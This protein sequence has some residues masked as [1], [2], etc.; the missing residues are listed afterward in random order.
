MPVN[1]IAGCRASGSTWWR[2]GRL[3]HADAVPAARV[4]DD[5][6]GLPRA[7]RRQPGDEVGEGVVG[8][9]EEHELGAGDDVGHLAHR[10]PGQEVGGPGEAR[11]RHRRDP[12]D[13]GGR[14]AA[15]AAPEHRADPARTDDSDG[16]AGGVLD[17]VHDPTRYRYCG[18]AARVAA[19]PH[20]RRGYGAGVMVP[21]REA[22]HDALYGPR[23]FYRRAEG[24]AGHFTTSTHGPLGAAPRGGARRL[25][26]REGATHVVDVGCGRGELLTHLHGVRPDLRLTGVDVVERPGAC[27]MP[28]RGSR[29]PGG[30]AL[31]DGLDDLD[32]RA[33]RRPRVA[34]RRAVHGR[35]GRGAGAAARSCSSTRRPVRSRSAARRRPTSSRG[36]RGTGPSR[37]CRCGAGSRSAPPGTWPGPTSSAAVRR[38]TLLAVDYGH[39]RGDRPAARHPHGIPRRHARRPGARRV[40][41]PHRARRRRRPRATTRCTTQRDG[42]ARPRRRPR[43]PPTSRL[44]RTD[45]A[46]YLAALARSSAAAA[47]TDPA[48]LGGVRV[49]A[50]PGAADVT[51]GARG[52][53]TV[54]GDESPYAVRPPRARRPRR[55]GLRRPDR[56]RWVDCP[57]RSSSP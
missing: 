21:W 32:R 12:G 40:V 48:G 27:R 36:A 33:R 35:R 3:E 26:E 39:T 44:A 22:W 1:V 13:A 19:G 38:G 55:A 9:G 2:A 24:P 17:A 11:L 7:G 57:P 29:S 47:L 41:R 43:R 30:G 45:P 31:P 23:G 51:A 53:G 4:D 37:T 15:R 34:R 5:L 25:A 46:A 8:H 20:R 42:A 10:H 56:L 49:G 6:A 54:D 50:A 52:R 28:W 16:E 14:P 18:P